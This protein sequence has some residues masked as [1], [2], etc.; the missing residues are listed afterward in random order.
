M[1]R[2]EQEYLSA[3]KLNPMDKQSALVVWEAQTPSLSGRVG[4]EA[5][6]GG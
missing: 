2:Q 4:Y 3:M 6:L 5:D 1:A